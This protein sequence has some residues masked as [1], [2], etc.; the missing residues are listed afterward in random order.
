MVFFAENAFARIT[1]PYGYFS[2]RKPSFELK[3]PGGR[4]GGIY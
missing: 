2:R 4:S 3:L 1:I